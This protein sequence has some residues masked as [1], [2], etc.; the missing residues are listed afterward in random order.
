[1]GAT[2]TDPTGGGATGNNMVAVQVNEYDAGSGGGDGNL[3]K[4][5]SPVDANSADDRI[6]TFGYDWR[7]RQTQATAPQDYYLANTFDTLDRVTQVDQYAQSTNNLI[8]R[9][10]TLYDNRGRV[11]QTVRYAVDPSTGTVGNN[12]TDNS[13]FDP[14]GNVI[15]QLPSGSSAFVKSVYDNLGRQTTQ[16]IGYDLSENSYADASSVSD[17]TIMEQVETAYDEAS[18]VIQTTTRQRFHDATGTGPLSYPGGSQPVARVTYVAIGRAVLDQHLAGRLFAVEHHPSVAPY[19]TA[20]HVVI[21][22]VVEQVALPLRSRNV[23]TVKKFGLA[24]RR[25][26]PLVKRLAE[27]TQGPVILKIGRLVEQPRRRAALPALLFE[28][29]LVV[30]K[31][32]KQ[33]V[34]PAALV[35]VVGHLPGHF[36]QRLTIT[37]RKRSIGPVI[38]VVVLDSLARQRC[39]P[40]RQVFPRRRGCQCTDSDEWRRARARHRRRRKRL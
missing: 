27:P 4:Q 33:R 38:A 15:K 34:V 30:Q 13:W 10:Q 37:G 29:V 32:L 20:D 9:S 5:T 17:D 12:L 18:N 8:G 28:V 39:G 2:D 22:H 6:W 36:H 11:Y 35:E 26:D 24:P 1:M 7:N 16:Y 14:S 21:E 31:A 3:T 19:R 23:A 25:I 40:A